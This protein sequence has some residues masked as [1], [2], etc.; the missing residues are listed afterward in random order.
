MT[1][2]FGMC[3]VGLHIVSN[4]V[5]LTFGI[6]KVTDKEIADMVLL[7][8]AVMSLVNGCSEQALAAATIANIPT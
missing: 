3:D 7:I 4:T 6:A 5:V 2:S 1:R 8:Y